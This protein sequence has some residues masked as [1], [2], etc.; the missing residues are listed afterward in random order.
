MGVGEGWA[1]WGGGVSG[2]ADSLDLDARQP[3][4]V[5]VLD[6]TDCDDQADESSP[7][8]RMRNLGQLLVAGVSK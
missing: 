7:E 8:I 4:A 3:C 1:G 6:V 5:W 2:G